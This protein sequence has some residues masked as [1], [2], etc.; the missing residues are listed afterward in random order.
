MFRRLSRSMICMVAVSAALGTTGLS[1]AWVK[2]IAH[3]DDDPA[4]E[5]MVSAKAMG[6]FGPLLGGVESDPTVQEFVRAVHLEAG[7][8]VVITASGE[9]DLSINATPGGEAGPDGFS[10]DARPGGGTNYFPLEEA[11]VDAGQ[12]IPDAPVNVGALIGAFVSDAEHGA[13][14]VARNNDPDPALAEA[15]DPPLT[16]D[17]AA[18][19][20]FYIGSQA[21]FVA[22]ASGWLFLGIN[23]A[24]T[25]NNVGAFTVLIRYE[26]PEV[27]RRVPSL[28]PDRC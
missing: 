19:S 14:F 5:V 17:L 16:G 27:V 20:L 15:P 26:L 28:V 13:D 2:G 12:P 1:L 6:G 24:F 23:D 4:I 11:R 10:A 18:K 25:P 8:A 7:E 9:I 21:S 22:P 3:A